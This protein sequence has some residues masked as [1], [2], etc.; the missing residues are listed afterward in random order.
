MNKDDDR[1]KRRA[2]LQAL[3]GRYEQLSP[4]HDATL[5]TPG[6]PMANPAAPAQDG[7]RGRGRQGNRRGQAGAG[8]G[9]ERQ[10]GGLLQRF[11]QFLA[12]TPPGDTLI[13]GTSIGEQRLQQVMRLLEQRG[14]TAQGG[15]NE[16]IQRLLKFLQQNIPGEPMTVGV[17]LRRLQQ[18]LERV[19]RLPEVDATSA[20]LPSMPLASVT[21]EQLIEAGKE[22]VPP[23]RESV[24]HAETESAGEI[25]ALEADIQRLQAVAQ[26]LQARLEQ[27]RKRAA[28]SPP[29]AR[30]AQ[31]AQLLTNNPPESATS[32]R[33]G[34][35]DWFLEFLE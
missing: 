6:T 13:P 5:T 23:P 11:A 24:L 10:S 19:N 35:D 2:R 27:A 17:N 3:R 22:E 30:P 26:D 7:R 14:R 33:A 31:H 15:V 25:A 32:P 18:M 34:G 20:V 9:G 16:R 12:E 8:P 4:A 1:A 21:R 29:D 28:L